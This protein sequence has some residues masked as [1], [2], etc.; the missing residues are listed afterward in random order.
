[1]DGSIEIDPGQTGG[2]RALALD[3]VDGAKFVRL[4]LPQAEVTEVE[5]TVWNSS[6]DPVGYGVTVMAYRDDVLGYTGKYF[7]SSLVVP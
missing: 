5:A 1:V 2:K 3:Y 4:Y 6:G 7:N